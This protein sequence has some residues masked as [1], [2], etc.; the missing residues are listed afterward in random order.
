MNPPTDE[1]GRHEAGPTE[2]RAAAKQL[3]AASVAQ[4]GDDPVE[5]EHPGF[6]RAQ[7]GWRRRIRC[8]RRLAPLDD[9]TVD[10]VAPGGRWSA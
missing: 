1:Q 9:G 3:G 5:A 8:S 4:A 7:G 6:R 10:P 2:N